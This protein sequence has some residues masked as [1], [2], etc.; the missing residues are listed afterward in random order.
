MTVQL[1][2]IEQLAPA[3]TT[4]DLAAIDDSLGHF[5]EWSTG[6]AGFIRALLLRHRATLLSQYGAGVPVPADIRF[7]ESYEAYRLD[8]AGLPAQCH[9]WAISDSHMEMAGG[10]G[11]TPAQARARAMVGLM[12]EING[13]ASAVKP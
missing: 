9:A 5:P 7:N 6:R 10:S 1:D 8:I 13:S 3:C 2:W 4:E 11:A 12:L